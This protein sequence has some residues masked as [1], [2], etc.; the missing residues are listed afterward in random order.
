MVATRSYTDSNGIYWD[1]AVWV[2]AA[3]GIEFSLSSLPSYTEFQA[4]FDMYRILK[5][6]VDFLPCFNSGDAN[7]ATSGG[8]SFAIPYMTISPDYDNADVPVNE[9]Q[10]NQYGKA[11]IVRLDKPFSMTVKPRVA[12]Q[13]YKDATTSGYGQGRYGQWIDSSSAGVE[14]Y[15]LKWFINTT[16]PGSGFLST[17]WRCSVK[18]TYTLGLKDTI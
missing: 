17:G 8:N 13:V 5:V 10:M 4:L 16:G 6:K 3:N 18:Y 15:G 9:Y 11:K 2:G 14:H 7:E 12:T 1:G